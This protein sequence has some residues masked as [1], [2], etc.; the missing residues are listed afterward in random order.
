MSEQ[1]ESTAD[2]APR[3]PET[4]TSILSVVNACL[5][6]WRAFLWAPVATAVLVGVLI[7]LSPSTF[8]SQGSFMPQQGETEIG[9]LSGIAAQF[10]MQLPSGRP[11]QSP[12]FYVMLLESRRILETVATTEYAVQR[13]AASDGAD[14][15]TDL[16]DLLSIEGTGREERVA[17]AIEELRNRINVSADL[18]TNV[19]SFSV[20]TPWADLSRQIADRILSLVHQFNV[21]TRQSQASAERDFLAERVE[22][23]EEELKA[24]EDSLEDFLQSNRQYQNS[25]ALTLEY[26]RL[27]RRVDLQQQ[28]YSSLAES[29][30]QAK[31][32]EVR[33]TPVLTVVEPPG[34][35]TRP[36]SKLLMVKVILAMMAGFVVAVFWSLG[37]DFIT[38]EVDEDGDEEAEFQRLAH[39]IARDL[40][41]MADRVVGLVPFV[42]N[43]SRSRRSDRT[44]GG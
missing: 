9:R 23:A 7:V 4:A 11:T 36:D 41:R 37:V 44:T 21:E 28:V 31:I 39:E 38:D 1:T 5:R 33:S 42:S 18:E 15:P 26:D 40:R 12:N 16:V 24:A 17:R 8:T 10:G 6:H 14:P 25:P 43:R 32:S 22:E 34:A 35:P 20:T 30:E 19:V 13:G 3:S 2:Q 27:Q 29:Y